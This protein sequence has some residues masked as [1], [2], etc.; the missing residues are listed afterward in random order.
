MLRT[1]PQRDSWVHVAAGQPAPHG[2][3]VRVASIPGTAP[4]VDGTLAG[5]PELCPAQPL[6][7]DR[8]AALTAL[9]S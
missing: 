3:T 6:Q 8:E 1:R 7:P 4:H 5:A 2:C 9:V